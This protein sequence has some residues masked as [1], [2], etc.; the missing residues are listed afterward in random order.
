MSSSATVAARSLSITTKREGINSKTKI[1]WPCDWLNIQQIHVCNRKSY[2][3]QNARN[4]EKPIAAKFLQFLLYFPSRQG[5]TSPKKYHLPF[6]SIL[7][8][9]KLSYLDALEISWERRWQSWRWWRE[10]RSHWLGE[11]STLLHLHL[12]RIHT[13]WK[14][15]VT[16]DVVYCCNSCHDGTWWSWCTWHSTKLL[17]IRV[18]GAEKENCLET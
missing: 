6:S 9:I 17:R 10:A 1:N 5:K 15:D 12:R 8:R 13:Q 3:W 11:G 7:V 14:C 18:T 4:V 2:I 16:L